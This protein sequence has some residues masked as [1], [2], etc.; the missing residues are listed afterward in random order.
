MA[1]EHDLKGL[2]KFAEREEWQE[3]FGAV[4]DAHF[5]PLL[6]AGDLDFEGIV[7]M[8]GPHWQGTLWGCAFE[9]FLTL[10]FDV[11]GENIVDEYLKRRSWR[12][13]PPAKAY[14]RALRSSI[15][16]LYEV[17]DVVPGESMKL[18]DLLRDREPV[19][20]SEHSATQN[21]KQWDRIAARAV[22]VGG[23]TIISGGLLPF[24]F[25]A[26]DILFDGLK[27]GL[28]LKKT[29]KPENL[30]DEQLKNLAPLL[31]LS[32][33]S[34][35]LEGA[36]F[37]QD[38]D[39][40][41]SDDEPIEFHD[42]RFPF[43]ARVTQKQIAARLN[44][45]T[46]LEQENTKLWKWL[47]RNGSI[48]TPS[49]ENDAQ[50]QMLETTMDDGSWVLG[51]IEM[52]G[53]TLLLSVNSAGRAERGRKLIEWALDD[54]VRNPLTE[55]R[56]VKQMM[57][58]VP[59]RS[60]DN[61]ENDIPPE[62]AEQI[63]RQH[64]DRHYWETLDLPVPALGNKTPRQA[65]KTKGGRKQVIDWLKYLENSSAKQAGSNDPMACY[66]FSWMW[67]ELGIERPA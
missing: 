21:L 15:M 14:M 37:R 56:T 53:K 18:R 2:M 40:I 24:S 6:D 16:S 29:Q 39:F 28:E 36:V 61:Q 58:D 66:D 63:L 67:E 49:A 42:I 1:S 25:K 19:I 26:C 23:K 46:E 47:D 55:I 11:P 51:N 9:D 4:M 17:S 5:G 8:V 31:T 50:G 32:W 57:E 52:K 22:E 3:C 38:P 41:N 43:A 10:E 30:S 45:T 62:I 64:L 20:V 33:L 7:D 44:E 60:E 27:E 13:K 34:D 35:V 54:L 65:A 59:D 48:N 12:E